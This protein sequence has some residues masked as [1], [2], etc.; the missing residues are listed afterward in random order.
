ME[1]LPTNE[2]LKKI[3]FAGGNPFSETQ[4]EEEDNLPKYFVDLPAFYKILDTDTGK[5]K[6]SILSAGRGCGK[7]ANRTNV[8]RWLK[9]GHP[10]S[11]KG[12]WPWGENIL[13][14]SYTNFD[15]IRTTVK[16]DFSK[17]RPEDHIQSVLWNCVS[18]LMGF[19]EQNWE[20]VHLV[21][22]TT[23]DQTRLGYF[24][25]HYSE[26]GEQL[27][28][29]GQNALIKNAENR[30]SLN[31]FLLACCAHAGKAER[32]S[33]GGPTALLRG[34]IELTAKLGVSHTVV[35]VD[36]ID[37]IDLT[38][39]NPVLGALLLKPLI[40]E[41][42]LMQMEGLTFKFFLPEQVVRKLK[43]LPETRLGERIKSYE[44]VW[45]DTAVQVLLSERLKAFSNNAL[46]DIG[47]LAAP[48][49]KDA[50]NIL[51]RHVNN[52]PRDLL[53]LAEQVLI[54]FEKQETFGEVKDKNR[55]PR[56]TKAIIETAI[57]FFDKN[58]EPTD[59]Y[60]NNKTLVE[61]ESSKWQITP[62]LQVVYKGRI[63]STEK[64]DPKEYEILRYF[65][66]HPDE[67]V[68]R[69][70]IGTAVWKD[71][72]INKYGWVLTQRIATL[73]EKIGADKIKTVRGLGYIFY[74]E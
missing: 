56:I 67:L 16:D 36:G 68:K 1:P 70:E 57:Y 69:D 65:F 63:I 60:R 55:R 47:Q 72:W 4:A 73:R 15:R 12:K 3:G 23:W 74:S 59:A 18:S 13:V 33:S 7:S 49:M 45:D 43:E 42:V 62:D 8:E 22:I 44:I 17:T 64:L 14:V 30:T 35:L 11:F 9:Q 2:F 34:F 6:S 38:A 40:A 28:E 71:K 58:I 50:G 46:R 52:N 37:E 32:L 39:N 54:Q 27:R 21:N 19:L 61:R 20:K 41:R 31:E 53:R 24:L 48:D 25:I 66:E 26:Q 5:P 10:K 51:A 29:D